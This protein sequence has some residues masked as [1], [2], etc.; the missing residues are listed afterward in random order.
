[1]RNLSNCENNID[2][3]L[4][5]DKFEKMSL[6]LEQLTDEVTKIRM[7]LDTSNRISRSFGLKSLRNSNPLDFAKDVQGIGAL[8]S[9]T[10]S[11]FDR[12]RRNGREE[13]TTF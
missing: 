10:F 13:K 11:L 7:K 2:K 3:E 6:K 8:L 4:F 1:M 12:L 5:L 9:D